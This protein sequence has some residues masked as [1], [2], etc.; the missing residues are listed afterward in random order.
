LTCHQ[1]PRQSDPGSAVSREGG[2]SSIRR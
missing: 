1:W 2:T